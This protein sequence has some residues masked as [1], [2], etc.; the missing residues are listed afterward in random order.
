MTLITQK[1]RF[2]EN[3]FQYFLVT[4][5]MDTFEFI[6]SK[7]KEV[8]NDNQFKIIFKANGKLERNLLQLAIWMSK[9]IKTHQIVWKTLRKCFKLNEELLDYVKEV[10]ARKNNILHLAV[11]FT[12]RDVFE[13]IFNQLKEVTSVKELQKLL[14]STGIFRKNILQVAAEQCK[15][16]EIHLVLWN[17]LWEHLSSS[18]LLH[19]INNQDDNGN[20]LIHNVI[21]WNTKEI[22]QLT[23]LEIRTIIS[24]KEDQVKYLNSKGHRE[25]NMI[26]MSSKNVLGGV[27]VRMLVEDLIAGI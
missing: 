21:L 27:E 16:I 18:E 5:N 12:S 22:I 24:K 13:F 25:M 20:C 4:K 9:D 7:F 8:F 17:I 19:L 14:K 26:E 11:Y 1:D 3:F 2:G 10:D 6:F 15:I 23:W